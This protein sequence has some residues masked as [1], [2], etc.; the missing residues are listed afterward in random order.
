MIVYDPY[1]DTFYDNSK[2]RDV[3]TSDKTI[4]LGNKPQEIS[5]R[6][7]K[8]WEEIYAEEKRRERSEE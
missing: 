4:S 1:T 6:N 3:I 2:K 8:M 7:L 5:G